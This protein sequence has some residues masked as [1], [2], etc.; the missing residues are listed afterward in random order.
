MARFASALLLIPL[1]MAAGCGDER[2]HERL[3][4]GMT[5]VQVESVLGVPVREF[6]EFSIRGKVRVLLFPT[7]RQVMA[8]IHPGMRE[9]RFCKLKDDAVFVVGYFVD[10]EQVPGH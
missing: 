5:R 8:E 9:Y 4:I 2:Q 1:L 10:N 6:D 3:R 7:D